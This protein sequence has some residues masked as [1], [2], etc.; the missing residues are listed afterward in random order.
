M[1]HFSKELTWKLGERIFMEK[2]EEESEKS[3]G[4]HFGQVGTCSTSVSGESVS[5]RR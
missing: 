3:A 1:L 5:A 2:R 4:L